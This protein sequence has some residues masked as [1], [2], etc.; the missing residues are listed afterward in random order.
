MDVCLLRSGQ[1]TLRFGVVEQGSVALG[2]CLS[3]SCLSGIGRP[4]HSATLVNGKTGCPLETGTVAGV[5]V[6]ARLVVA[7][8]LV[9][10]G[11]VLQRGDGPP[12]LGVVVAGPSA[13]VPREAEPRG[14]ARRDT[15]GA[16]PQ[17]FAI[18]GA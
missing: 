15:S 17:R 10:V 16:A 14:D 9:P 6:R 13:E 5:T 11:A 1:L 3:R 12:G 4:E 2:R 18:E 7:S 8:R